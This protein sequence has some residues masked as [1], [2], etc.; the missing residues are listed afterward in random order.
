MTRAGHPANPLGALALAAAAGGAFAWGGVARC[1]HHHLRGSVMA[2]IGA[3]LQE[4]PGGGVDL[5][6]PVRTQRAHRRPVAA[7]PLFRHEQAVQAVQSRVH[8]GQARVTTTRSGRRTLSSSRV[9]VMLA[10]VVASVVP[11]P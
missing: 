7:G 6:T 3:S 8:R 2:A 1:G 10:A 11:L 5:L 4:L 9:P